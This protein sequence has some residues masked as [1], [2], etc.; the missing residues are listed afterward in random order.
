MPCLN[1]EIA[2]RYIPS[3]VHN[4]HQQVLCSTLRLNAVTV[5]R[6]CGVVPIRAN[7]EPHILAGSFPE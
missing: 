3:T 1:V 4:R 6:N 7:S 2:R 5:P